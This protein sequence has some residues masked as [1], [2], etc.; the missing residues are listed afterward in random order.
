MSKKV[1][2]EVLSA[3]DNFTI[4]ALESTDSSKQRAYAV[5]ARSIA[6]CRSRPEYRSPYH[7][8]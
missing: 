7:S 5:N 1:I 2:S 4:I 3:A 6:V 8:I